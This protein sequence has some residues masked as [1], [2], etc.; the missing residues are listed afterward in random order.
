MINKLVQRKKI[1]LRALARMIQSHEL[2]KFIGLLFDV[3]NP[4]QEQMVEAMTWFLALANGV[5]IDL[6]LNRAFHHTKETV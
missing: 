4:S 5:K 3:E 2:K 6:V 1:S